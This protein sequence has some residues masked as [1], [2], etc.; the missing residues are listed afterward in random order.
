MA[1][2]F[3]VSAQVIYQTLAADASLVALLGEYRFKSGD[4]AEA[5]SI[6]T[7]G[8]DLPM[9]A[10]TTGVEVVIHDVG[11]VT[12]DQ[13]LTDSPTYSTTWPVFVICWDGANGAQMHE[14]AQKIC[15]HFMGSNALQ[16]V[17]AADGVGA[18]VQTKIKIRSDKPIIG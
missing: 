15:S 11:D 16:T 8:S 18:M 9:L 12:S 7:P 14:V 4:T 1:Q 13:Y 17:A 2:S 6:M 10:S 5:M 3:P